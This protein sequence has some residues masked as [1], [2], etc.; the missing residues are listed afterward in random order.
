MEGRAMVAAVIVSLLTISI[1]PSQLSE[2]PND[3]ES[4]S[5]EST[6]DLLFIG[7]SYTANNQLNIRVENLLNAAGFNPDTQSLTSGG[8]TLSWH[9]E[10]TESEGSDWYG[11]L[12]TPHDFVILQDQS[13][14]PGFPTGSA[15]WQDS[16]E[17]AQ[18]ID[19]LVDQNG[20]D[21]FFLMTWGYRNGDPN[22]NW[23][24]PDYQTMQQ[25]L[26]SGY[27]AYAENLSSEERPVFIAPVGIAYEN[28]FLSIPNATEEGTIFSDLYASDGS[29]PSIQGTYLA[30]CVIHSSVT[31]VSS[32]GLPSTGGIN[33]SRTLELQ[34]WAD[35]TVFNTSGFTYPWQLDGL[36]VEFGTDSGSIFNIEPGLTIGISGNFTNLAEVNTTALIQ[37]NGPDG[38]IVSWDYPTSPIAG[39]SF[40]APSDLVQ[41]VEFRVTAPEVSSG[42]PLADSIHDFSLALEGDRTGNL[43]W[44]NFSLRYGEWKGVNLVQGGGV[45]SIEPGG[46]IDL[47]FDI[48]NIGNSINSMEFKIAAKFDNG[49]MANSPSLSFSHEGWTAIVYDR[50]GLE[51][52]SPG[53]ITKVRMQVKAPS[54]TS[55]KLE[56]HVQFAGNGIELQETNQSVTIVPR[57]GGELGLTNI[58]CIFQVNPGESCM[59]ELFIENTGDATY[60]FNLTI[61]KKPHWLE[62]DISQFN[63]NLGPGQTVHGIEVTASTREGLDAEI[64]GEVSIELEVDGWVPAEV[65]FEVEIASDFAWEIIRSDAEVMNERLTG[66][67]EVKNIGNSPDGLVVAV[68]CS[69]FT[70]FG[71]TNLGESGGV[72]NLGRSFEK[73]NIPRNGTVLFEVWMDIPD[74]VPIAAEAVLTVEVRSFRDPSISYITE[75]STEI[76]RAQPSQPNGSEETSVF[77]EFLQRWLQTILIII[78]SIIGSISVAYA[79]R[80]RIEAD[81]EHYRKTN[82]QITVEE[83]SE[84]WMKKFEKI[85]DLGSPNINSPT[86]NITE[87]RREF[88]E[89]S[90]DH[91]RAISSGPE[92][93]VIDKA[94]ET[95]DESQAED[96]FADAIELADTL[97]DS[98][99]IHPDNMVLDLDDFDE[100]L[101][102]LRRGLGD[103]EDL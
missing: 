96:A 20:G 7:N 81:R 99:L 73:L 36:G 46:I 6:L 8:K 30:A 47:E 80:N 51:A 59:V 70:N 17:G 38:W 84:N 68:E 2:V 22:N 41:W 24:Y 9:G 27:I 67:W 60:D 103:D 95:L 4:V 43:D 18:I 25:H 97:Q 1:T 40:D 100:K 15:S 12:R 71:I 28:I 55:G 39:Y 11:A 33:G 77:S 87:F 82:T 78:V 85:E 19:Q 76:E 89:K 91:S 83:E 14:I 74:E 52:M 49:S 34:Q 26:K 5:S 23:R 35:H 92:S 44:W 94:V 62:V 90:G 57:S 64:S 63:G 53:E 56:M 21:L 61:S 48:Q 88:L 45:A 13:Q 10:Q 32:I 29:H 66:Y 79:I 101:D 50:A 102:S 16:M 69:D 3:S 37:I 72:E 58:D 42:Y 93:E 98:D 65:S 75:H 54:S 31:G 86:K